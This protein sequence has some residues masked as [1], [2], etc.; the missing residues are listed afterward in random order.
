MADEKVVANVQGTHIPG[1]GNEQIE[2]PVML[3]GEPQIAVL[4]RPDIKLNSQP[5]IVVA[6][7]CGHKDVGTIFKCQEDK[8]GCG[9]QWLQSGLRHPHL[10]PFHWVTA[11]MQ[12]VPPLN[13]TMAYLVESG[14][15]SAEARQIMTK[16]AIRMGS[17]YIL[18]WDDDT[19]PEDPKALYKMHIFLEMHPEV[20]AISAIYT[21]REDPPVPLIFEKHGKGAGWE[22]PMGPGSGVTPIFGAGA[23]F[24]LARTK[25]IIDVIEKMK[26]ENGGK[27]VAIWQDVQVVGKKGGYKVDNPRAEQFTTTWGHDVRFCRL[28]NTHDWP[29]YAH[30]EILCGHYDIEAGVMYK[31]PRDA[32]GFVKE[33]NDE[34]A[35]G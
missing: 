35:K 1:R 31:V 7:P 33:E 13:C 12:M 27:E 17:K 19:I 10:F 22:I 24:L 28:L 15:L 21:T 30:G 29:V 18:Y 5:E 11:N 9:K 34:Q 26:A 4:R 25:A 3:D 2:N 8:G 32:P 20:G 6:L 14:R 16:K 23:G